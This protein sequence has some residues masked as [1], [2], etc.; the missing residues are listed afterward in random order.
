MPRSENGYLDISRGFGLR[1]LVMYSSDVTGSS[2]FDDVTM[3]SDQASKP[4]TG[5][6]MQIPLLTLSITLQSCFDG[7]VPIDLRFR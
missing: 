6:M 3:F 5:R 7:T 2:V 1:C 4:S